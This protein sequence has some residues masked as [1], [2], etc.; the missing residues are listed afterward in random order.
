LGLEYLERK[1][2]NNMLLSISIPTYNR[3]HYLSLCLESI[4]TQI[5][6]NVELKNKIELIVSNNCSTDDTDNVIDYFLETY[7]KLNIKASANEKNIG[8]DGNITKAF[9]L[10][11]GDFVLVFGDDDILIPGSLNKIV[12]ILE[13]NPECGNIYINHFGFRDN[14]KNHMPLSISNS[15]IVYNKYEDYLDYVNYYVTYTSGNIINKKKLDN[16]FDVNRFLGTNLN[17]LNWIFA[18]IKS[19]PYNIFIN[20]NLIG[21]KVENAG[22]YGFC[23]TFGVNGNKIFDYYRCIGW[24]DSIFKNIN[25]NMLKSV[26]PVLI[27]ICK[28]TSGKFFKEDY[29]DVLKNI[30]KNNFR[31][32]IFC[33]PII[34]LNKGFAKLY[35]LGIR[36]YN[37]HY[38]IYKRKI[39]LLLLK[40]NKS[41]V[42]KYI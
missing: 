2:K 14:Y 17:L 25:N 41:I 34:K 12:K 23:E 18:A 5:Q 21:M 6:E 26:F 3:S 28:N 42:I 10:A 8:L 4:I 32:W 20:D 36:I 29:L 31:F 37:Q 38:S 30:Y 15:Y 24:P 11:Q 33:Y 19:A 13:E 7:N 16:T 40:F 9:D 35:M 39:H 22:G 1:L 27:L